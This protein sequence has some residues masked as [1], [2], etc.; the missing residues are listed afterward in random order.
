MASASPFKR[1][2]IPLATL[3]VAA[4]L[5]PLASQANP[6][7]ANVT[8]GAATVSG[9][10]TA[11]VTVNQTT[12]RAFIQWDNFSVAKGES[13]RFNQPSA[14]SIT[15][16]KVV[17]VAP[18]EILGAVSANGRIILI[19]PNGIFFGKGS[20][21]DAAG[22]IATT[23]DLDQSS[24]LSGGQLKFT[25]ATDLPGSVVN[26]GTLTI[27]D[28]GLGAL[29][30]PYVRNSGAIF[31]NLGTVALASG[32]TLT[33]DFAGDGLITFALGE[34]LS[35]SLVGADGKPLSAQV[36]HAGEITAGRVVLSA[37]AAR[38]V[39]NQ[40]VNVTGL[41]RAASGGRNADGSISLRGSKSVNVA[42][43]AEVSGAKVS[44]DADN[45]AVAGNI[46]AGSIQLTGEHVA[47]LAGATLSSN[48]GSIL[49][50][51]DWQ[52]SNGVRQAL[53]TTL[54]DGATIDAG[55]GGTAV[56][57]S[58]ITNTKSVT[59][60]AGTVRALG[61]RIETSG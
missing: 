48:G 27:S 42:A 3:L 56:L 21:V 41:V 17:G 8:G 40:S 2:L 51:G 54:S 57:W 34:G 12:D 15:A 6:A 19:N 52:G 38:E 16:N 36:E 7:G 24:F 9:Q 20:T 37:A 43:G 58:D 46:S 14:T 49:V 5:D 10:G 22:L 29:V 18:S 35:A 4:A 26:E 28:A 25:A 50:G 1:R 30:A 13:V 31:A 33:V 32:K 53:I 45:V 60:V 44:V 59:T 55:Q 47:V 61:V 11:R 23:L 39:V